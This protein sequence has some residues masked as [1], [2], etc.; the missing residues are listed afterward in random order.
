MS[1]LNVIERT[2]EGLMDN[3]TPLTRVQKEVASYS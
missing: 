1:R 3:R 2:M